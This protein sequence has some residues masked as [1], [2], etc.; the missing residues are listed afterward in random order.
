MRAMLRV[1]CPVVKQQ[2]DWPTYLRVITDGAAGVTIAERSGIPAST[3]SRWL[4]GEFDPKPRQVVQVARAYGVSALEA[5][6]AAKYLTAEEVD[7]AATTPREFQLREFTEL[8]IANEIVR[9]I[10]EGESAMLESPLDE[11]HPAM[12]NVRPLR[13]DA[14]TPQKVKKAAL[15]DPEMNQDEKFD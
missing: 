6:I 10:A 1:W 4:S 13:D 11:N 3:I 8:E 2:I 7:L 9:R 14:R 12:Q 15:N 5:L